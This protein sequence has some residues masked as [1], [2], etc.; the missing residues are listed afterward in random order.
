MDYTFHK[1]GDLLV[2]IIGIWGHNCVM[3]RGLAVASQTVVMDP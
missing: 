2:L 3:T 1:W